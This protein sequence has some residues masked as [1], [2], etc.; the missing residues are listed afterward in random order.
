MGTQF[1]WIFDAAVAA[2]FVGFIFIGIKKGFV[3]VLLSLLALILAFCTALFTSEG[4]AEAIYDSMIS[5]AITEEVKGQIDGLL[6]DGLVSELI[7]QDLTL[8]KQVWKTSIF[9]PWGFLPRRRI[10]HW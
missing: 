1:F 3:S 6:G 4:I 5:D 10:F 8:V 7:F 9:P 2:I